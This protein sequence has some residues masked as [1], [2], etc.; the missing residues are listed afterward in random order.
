MAFVVSPLVG[1]G[2][3]K[4][5]DFSRLPVTVLLRRRELEA[6]APAPCIT[7]KLKYGGGSWGS[8]L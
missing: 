5:G 1:V 4:L 8:R 3:L 2:P 7:N 6:M